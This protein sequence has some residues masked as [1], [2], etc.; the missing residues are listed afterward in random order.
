MKKIK[1]LLLMCLTFTLLFVPI[2]SNA[3]SAPHLNAVKVYVTDDPIKLMHVGNVPK[4]SCY[5]VV[6][7]IGT[8]GSIKLYKNN[9]FLYINDDYTLVTSDILTDG[10]SNV[11][12]GMRRVYKL[13][14]AYDGDLGT[15][16][17]K[18]TDYS[19][20]LNEKSSSCSFE[21][22][23]DEDNG[24]DID[25]SSWRQKNIS[26]SGSDYTNE[27]YCN[28]N[29]KLTLK[30]KNKYPSAKTYSVKLHY[31]E[32]KNGHWL[33]FDYYE[34][35]K[36]TVEAGETQTIEVPKITN[37]SAYYKYYIDGYKNL[38]FDGK[39]EYK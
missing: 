13:N 8:S 31:K 32:K 22:V 36:G 25:T 35:A 33:P 2:I 24:S 26:G 1:Y 29:T 16:L 37:K 15:I 20:M 39:I 17:V 11:G 27:F 19:D 18:A 10:S 30:F 21:V 34:I 6:E 28:G 9:S 38:S 23:K 12:I 3:A 5:I 4:D 7:E 14:S